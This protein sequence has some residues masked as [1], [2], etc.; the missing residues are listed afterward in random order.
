M[1]IKK[2]DRTEDSVKSNLPDE[3]QR[4][5]EHFNLQND[6]IIRQFLSRGPS[7]ALGED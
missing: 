6:G 1:L 7:L 3:K 4:E 5:R 2:D